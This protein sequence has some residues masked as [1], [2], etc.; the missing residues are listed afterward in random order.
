MMTH[1]DEI[2]Q[3]TEFVERYDEDSGFHHVLYFD[4]DAGAFIRES[5]GFGFWDGD[6][7]C[8]GLDSQ[9]AY[10]WLTKIV[11]MD[12]DEAAILVVGERGLRVV[13]VGCWDEGGEQA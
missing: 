4:P 9:E 7:T 8:A 10:E 11:G 2:D 5:R 3:I 12:P 1:D 6:L 13:H